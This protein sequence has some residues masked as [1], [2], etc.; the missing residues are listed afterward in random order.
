MKKYKIEKVGINTTG[1][2]SVFPDVETKV[3]MTSI[4]SINDFILEPTIPSSYE[5]IVNCDSPDN[6]LYHLNTLHREF[7]DI[8][9]VDKVNEDYLF[10]KEGGFTF[11]L[12][13]NEPKSVGEIKK[14][15][16]I[17]WISLKLG[18]LN[19]D[20][21]II[22]YC[23]KS[24]IKIIGLYDENTNI[25]LTFNLSFYARYCN[26]VLLPFSQDFNNQQDYLLS[27]INLDSPEQL[28]MTK[29]IHKP[30]NHKLG[31]GVSL[32]LEDNLIIPCPEETTL[33]YP[34]EVVFCLGGFEDECPDINTPQDEV[35]ETAYKLW[36]S[37][38][39]DGINSRE[40]LLNRFRYSMVSLIDK[41]YNIGKISKYAIVFLIKEKKHE[42]KNYLAFINKNGDLYFSKL[43]NAEEA[44]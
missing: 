35:E 31:I 25:P 14:A 30:N 36:N 2:D 11:E 39:K 41:P 32:K 1:Y 34:E 12:G 20:Y 22:K 37:L 43:Q 15:E 44:E 26:I 10:L 42:V 17:S 19:F 28:E 23:E 33:L 21:E 8:V 7:A 27:L 9:L 40:G 29:S 6:L 18:P 3:I 38:D 5:L 16:G 13:L 24:G 4:E